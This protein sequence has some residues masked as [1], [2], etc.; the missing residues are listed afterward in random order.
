VSVCVCEKM[1]NKVKIKYFILWRK[2]WS[3]SNA[4]KKKKM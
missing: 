1:K 4:K 3:S 2:K